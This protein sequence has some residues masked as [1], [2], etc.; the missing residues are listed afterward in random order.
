MILMCFLALEPTEYLLVLLQ[1]QYKA[2]AI[3][4]NWL[5]LQ[6]NQI[7]LPELYNPWL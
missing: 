4:Q 3:N 6:P 2:N 1:L 7:Q 5:Q